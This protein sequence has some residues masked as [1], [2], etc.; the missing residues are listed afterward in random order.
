MY[1]PEWSGGLVPGESAGI[2]VSPDVLARGRR[3]VAVTGFHL[4]AAA[5][6]LSLAFALHFGIPL[7]A[8]AAAA[9][10]G[11]LPVMVLCRLAAFARR[12]LVR[13]SYRYASAGDLVALAL[14]VAE[15]TALFVAWRLST[16]GLGAIPVVVLVLDG[17]LL[18]A[19]GSGGYL[20]GRLAGARGARRA[21]GRRRRRVLLVGAGEAAERLVH[22]FALDEQSELEPVGLVD[23]DP[24]KHGLRLHGIPV[25]G[26]V[27]ELPRLAAASGAELAAIAIAEP[28]RGQI[29][30]IVDRCR[31]AGL[32]YRIIPPLAELMSGRRRLGDLRGV[33]IEDLLGRGA[34]RLNLEEV[35]AELGGTTVLVTGGAG[36]IGSELARQIAALRPRRLVLLDQAESPLYFVA[37]ELREA[38]PAVEVVPVIGSVVDHGTVTRLFAAYRPDLVFHA[39]AYKHVPLME[40]HVAEAVRNNVFG[41]LVVAESA[42]LHGT[43]KMMLVSTDKAVCPSS[44]MGATKRIGERMLLGLSWLRGAATDFR[45]VRFGNVLGSAGSVV[46]LFRRQLAAGG[47][48][49]VTDPRMTRYFMTIPEAAQ[50]VLRANALPEAAGRIAMLDM[51][52]PV[53][54]VQ[55]AEDVARLSGFEP[56]TEMPI[57]FTGLRPGEKLHEALSSAMEA[58]SPSPVEK[59]RLLEPNETDSGAIEAGLDGLRGALAALDRERMLRRI[60]TLVPECVDPLRS[61]VRAASESA[62]LCRR[63]RSSTAPAP[64]RKRY[65]GV[66]RRERAPAAGA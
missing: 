19:F 8:R 31:A 56:Y 61:A 32:E 17:L 41:T 25:L 52:E 62:R 13:R 5:L 39:A 37:L 59:I 54:I 2:R 1:A 53:P 38:H 44:V 4:A 14:A 50:L 18:M 16:G 29:H 23:D 49:T 64:S 63:L 57:V 9:L 28:T 6:S 47:P 11:A 12:R 24:S 42:A 36:S 33:D 22:Q 48:L 21:D 51:G 26:T 60:G 3:T 20:A 65:P 34:V 55:L 7:P 46:P 45:V 66:R 27:E 35:R 58:A 15:G 30:R 43:R 40:D 10:A